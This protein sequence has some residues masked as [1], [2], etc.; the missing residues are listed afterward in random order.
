MSSFVAVALSLVFGS[1]F[2]ACLALFR[3]GFVAL[4]SSVEA[5]PATSSVGVVKRQSASV[6]WVRFTLAFL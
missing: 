1:L 5:P 4:L 3:G 2:V 6:L